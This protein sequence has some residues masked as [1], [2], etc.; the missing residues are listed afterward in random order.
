MVDIVF[1]EKYILAAKELLG[2]EMVCVP[3]CSIHYNRY[4]DWHRD[5]AIMEANG[6]STHTIPTNRLIQGGL[7]LQDN[8]YDGGGL[9]LIPGS[10]FGEDKFKK[11]YYGSRY[12][13]V[14]NGFQKILGISLGQKIERSSK[15]VLPATKAGDVL[16][17]DSYLDHRASFSRTIFGKAKIPKK[18]KFAIFNGFCSNR[19]MAKDYLQSIIRPDEPYA[20]FLKQATTPPKLVQKTR[21]LKFEIE[22]PS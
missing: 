18:E 3:E 13:K 9:I 10:N 16:F 19:R 7:Y 15:L 11:H 12:D 1:K 20:N 2:P 21:E 5:T 8:S 22:Y 4:F 17:F 14:I 6:L